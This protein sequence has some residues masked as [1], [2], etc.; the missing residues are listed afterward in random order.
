MNNYNIIGVCFL[1]QLAVK[2][3][4]ANSGHIHSLTGVITSS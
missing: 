2:K 3:L 1:D 4:L